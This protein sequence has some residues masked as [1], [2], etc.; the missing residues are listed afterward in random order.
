MLNWIFVFLIALSVLA[1]AFTGKMEA[2]TLGSVKNAESAVTI[3]IKLIAQMTLWLGLMGVVREAGLLRSLA[4]WLRPVMVRLFPDVPA[5]HPAMGAMIMNFAANILG[6]GNAATPFGLKAMSE[7][8]KLN[9][10]PGVASNAMALFLAINTSGLAVLAL[11]VVA[12]RASLG[13]KDPGG[14]IVPSL[15]AHGCNTVVTIILCKLAQNQAMFRPEKYLDQVTPAAA[16]VAAP[17]DEAALKKAEAEAAPR[18]PASGWRLFATL[19]V[20]ATL[21]FALGL[22]VAEHRGM[23]AFL[24]VMGPVF[25]NWLLPVLM[26]AIVVFGMGRQ[27]KVYETFV[28]AAKEGFNI[29]VMIIPYLVAIIVAVGM[30]QDSGLMDQ[31][32]KALAPVTLPLGFPLESLPMALMRPLS[33]SGAQGV[34]I[35]T[36]Q[37]HGPDSFIGY[38]VSVLN[39]SMETT[40]YVLAVYYGAVQV[41]TMRHTV[42]ACLLADVGG[43][44]AAT[45]ATHLFFGRAH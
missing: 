10:Y 31:M 45:V 41:K 42:L 1:A 3:A 4:R 32:V 43:V 23:G 33:G 39:G 18:P 37:Q 16:P 11:G 35:A 21:L 7:L 2:L 6:L 40:F 12:I 5:D 15:I 14:I 38:H 36:L 30:F 24:D 9:R 20:T 19:G 28:G 29:G 17:V 25:S 34:L 44:T 13:S 22:Y 26:L 8:N 27:V